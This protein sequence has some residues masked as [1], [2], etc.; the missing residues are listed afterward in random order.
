M[1]SALLIAS[2]KLVERLGG[3]R[4]RGSGRCRLEI[5]A[6]DS[7][8][9]I[10]WLE[11]TSSP[12]NWSP[13]KE[14]NASS[15]TRQVADQTDPWICVPLVLQLQGPLA[16]S[17]HTTG[18][19]VETLDFVPG[20]YL[21]PHV[22]RTLSGLGLDV[23]S[24]LQ[25]GDLC[26]LP[27]YPEVDGERGQPVPMALFA[28]KGLENP[29]QGENRE[30]VVNRLLQAEPADGTQLKQMREG[31]V[32]TQPT[33]VYKTP[34]TVRTHNTVEDQPQRPTSDVGGVYTYEAIAPSDRGTPV[35]LRS[36]LRIRKSLADRMGANW[37]NRLNGEVSLG[38][39]KKDDY[40]SVRLNA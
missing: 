12:T 2:A 30:R 39:S 23:R 14:C 19:V 40:G 5:L 7:D 3:K 17:Y 31:Y 35:V 37:W 32:S 20:S 38:R 11:R 21:L 8:K 33:K 6:A 13:A 28:P 24:A 4:R 22:T 36:E 16:V 10:A 18:N 25:S 29:L 9:A 27:A 34:I 15:D 1:A 26:V